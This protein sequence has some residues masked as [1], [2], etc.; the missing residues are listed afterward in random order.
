MNQSQFISTS[1][2]LL[3]PSVPPSEFVPRAVA[4]DDALSY[5][6]TASD[7]AQDLAQHVSPRTWLNQ[8]P[9]VRIGADFNRA[10]ELEPLTSSR[11]T[12]FSDF[13]NILKTLDVFF[14][15]PATVLAVAAKDFLERDATI[16]LLK[17]PRLRTMLE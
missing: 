6:S 9:A 16:P 4:D 2:E 17:Y 8:T 12:T 15:E 5:A 14:P 13:M 10:L 11:G 1:V 7:L 3:T